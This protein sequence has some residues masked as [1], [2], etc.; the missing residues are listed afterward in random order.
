MI[1]QHDD[2]RE[3]GVDLVQHMGVTTSQAG[4]IGCDHCVE[5][6]ANIDQQVAR[7][8][9]RVFVDRGKFNRW[10]GHKCTPETWN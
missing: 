4:V 5:Q 2:I 9:M 3:L 1:N 7:Y 8:K 10:P 6:L